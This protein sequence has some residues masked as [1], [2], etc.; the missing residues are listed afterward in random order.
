MAEP[1]PPLPGHVGLAVGPYRQSERPPFVLQ[2]PGQPDRLLGLQPLQWELEEDARILTALLAADKRVRLYSARFG[3][4][5]AAAHLATRGFRISLGVALGVDPAENARELDSA[6]SLL[7][8]FPDRF[9]RF[10][11]GNETQGT[12]PNT[13][14]IVPLDDLLNYIREAKD[15]ANGRV[16]IAAAEVLSVWSPGPDQ[17]NRRLLAEIDDLVVHVYGYWDGVA[18]DRAAEHVYARLDDL[19]AALEEANLSRPIILGETGWPVGGKANGA[20][21]PGGDQQSRFLRD[22]LQIA[23]ERPEYPVFLFSAFSEPWKLFADDDLPPG[24]SLQVED[25]WGLVTWHRELQPS[26]V[27]V[28]PQPPAPR[29][30]ASWFWV[31]RRGQL[32]P[33][34]DAGVTSSDGR[35][36]WLTTEDEQLVLRYAGTGCWGS[37][38]V[39]RGVPQSIMPR[40]RSWDLSAYSHLV[41]TLSGDAG[42][43]PL[44]IAIKDVDD[45]DDGSETKLR[46]VGLSNQPK[47]LAIPLSAFD[48]DRRVDRAHVYVD[49]GLNINSHLPHTV[50]LHSAY[51]LPSGQSPSASELSYNVVRRPSDGDPDVFV[52]GCNGRWLTLNVTTAS[53]QTAGVLSDDPAE[54]GALRIDAPAGEAFVSVFYHV[55]DAQAPPRSSHQNFSGFGRLRFE[56]RGDQGGEPVSVAVKDHLDD[57]PGARVVLDGVEP[58]WRE[59]SIN[60]SQFSSA[61]LKRL[62]VVFEVVFTDSQMHRVWFRNVRYE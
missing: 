28:L 1:P 45:P 5:D 43:E 24:E 25:K 34:H 10:I 9:E 46:I 26:L 56:L 47:S 38:F 16:Q 62:S 55:G 51:Y 59:F 35:H 50:R 3:P 22:F 14:G 60:L 44:E 41:L 19:R 23:R 18:V 6:F 17:L 40:P 36:D 27:D 37:V 39:T 7:D 4:G 33:G 49:L 57:G 53:G 32:S 31:F 61:D 15:R 13:P 20:A 21:Q 8:R 42:D 48:A 52:E 12:G 11:I 30:E 2:Q 29:P 58:T 54:L